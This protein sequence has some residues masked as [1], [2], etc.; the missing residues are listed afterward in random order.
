MIRCPFNSIC[1]IKLHRSRICA[2]FAT[3]TPLIPYAPLYVIYFCAN[4]TIGTWNLQLIGRLVFPFFLPE[5]PINRAR[6]LRAHAVRLCE[7]FLR[8]LPDCLQRLIF[9]HQRLA[10]CRSDIRNVI[11]HGMYLL[12]AP[13]RPV[14][15]N[16]K[17][18]RLV[19]NSRNQLKSLASTVDGYLYIMI[20]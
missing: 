4:Y 2:T 17:T 12:L 18:V 19:L 3:P 1:G 7:V 13:E 14:V 10:P 20:V 8:R 11:Q 6:C 15:L 5:K 9:F 16:R